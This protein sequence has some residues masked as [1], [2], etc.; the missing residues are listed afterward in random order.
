M[1]KHK[2]YRPLIALAA[3]AVAALAMAAL[4]FANVT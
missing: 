4:M 2:S 1:P 3:L